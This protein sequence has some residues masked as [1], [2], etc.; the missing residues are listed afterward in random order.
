VTERARIGIGRAKRIALVGHDNRKPDLMD[1]ARFNRGHLQQHRLYATGT[2]GRLLA[3][4]LG[5]DVRVM[6][7]GP[8][9]GDWKLASRPKL[10]SL[11]GE[12]AE[13]AAAA[14]TS[15][16]KMGK[17]FDLIAFD[18][19]DTLWHNESVYQAAQQRLVGL[20]AGY[21]DGET[22]M[23][24]LYQTEMR[25][26]PAYGYGIKS[27][28][29]SMIETAIRLSDGGISG[30]E[31]EQI[32]CLAREMLTSGVRL[33]DHVEHVVRTLAESYPLM[34]ITKGDLRDQ[35]AKLA[36]SGL[37]EVFQYVEVVTEKDCRVYRRLLKGVGVRP[38][39]FVMVGNS[40]RSDVLPVVELGGQAVYVPYHVTWEHEVVAGAQAE[41]DGYHELDDL[42]QLPALLQ[43]LEQEAGSDQRR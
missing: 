12:R 16:L 31:I 11:R 13:R 17:L 34:L 38:E 21:A 15:C 35:K 23:A 29:L 1:W 26:L 19:D 33:L 37:A 6:E 32:I 20:L 4:E 41:H 14:G 25:N 7:S 9:S 30:A 2:T 39:R 24:E 22:V 3:D 42:G 36:E 10:S 8:L 18:G 28:A 5:F 27:F 40:L 43:H